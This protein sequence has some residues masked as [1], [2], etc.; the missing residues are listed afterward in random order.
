MVLD[1]LLYEQFIHHT[2]I[3]LYINMQFLSTQ[4]HT[5]QSKSSLPWIT[6]AI[7]RLIRKRDSLYQRFKRSSRPKHRKQFIATRHMVKAMIKQAYDSYLE[8]L[9]GISNPDPNTSPAGETGQSKSASKKLFSF[10]EKLT[11]GLTRY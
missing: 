5:Y 4:Q 3:N 9:L 7:K 2:Q 10:F 8:D 6:Q 1:K 11:P